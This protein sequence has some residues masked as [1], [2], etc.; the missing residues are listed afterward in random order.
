MLALILSSVP[1]A[2]GTAAILAA[3]TTAIWLL[4][5]RDAEVQATREA[6][7]STYR[8]LAHRQADGG[9]AHH[10][11]GRRLAGRRVTLVVAGPA[12]AAALHPAPAHLS[13]VAV[14][15]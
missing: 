11:A 15:R 14:A 1:H 2:L 7:A 8:G 3:G 4:P 9:L 10:H 6:L 5:W 12:H 13:G